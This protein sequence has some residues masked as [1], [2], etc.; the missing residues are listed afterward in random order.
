MRMQIT[1]LCYV[2]DG[3]KVLLIEKK[4]GFGKDKVNG[5][6]GKMEAGESPEDAVKR[7][8]LEET[9][10]IVDPKF[11]GIVEFNND[12][13]LDNLCFI[14][15]ADGF[16]GEPK[17]TEEARPFW[18]HKDEV[19]LSRMWEDDKYW[20]HLVLNGKKIHGRFHF[21]NWKLVK[22]QVHLLSELDHI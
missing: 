14:F 6:G 18:V 4:R 19:P 10:I 17:E 11:S 5:P 21:K 8:V 1:N 16:E 15:V 2:L 7:E 3:E 20:L 9:G 12:G 22:H 13:S